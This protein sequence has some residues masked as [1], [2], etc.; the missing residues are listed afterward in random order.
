[1]TGICVGK[2]RHEC[3]DGGGHGKPL[4][5]FLNDDGTYSGFCFRCGEYVEDPFEGKAAP[6][7]PKKKT[8]EQIAEELREIS[9]EWGTQSVRDIRKEVLEHLGIKIGV[10]ETDGTTPVVMATPYYKDGE[11][12]AYKQ[13]TINTTP[14]KVWS[15]GDQSDVDLFGWEQAT[16]SGMKRLYITEGECFTPDAEVLTES[17]WITL[18]E[19]SM[20]DKVCQVNQD[21]TYSFVT[22]L[23][24]VKKQYEGNLVEY[25]SGSY[26][27]LT[28]P[29]HN[30]VRIHHKTG[31]LVKQKACDKKFY[32]AIPR[33]VN[34]SKG[35]LHVEELTARLQ[36]MFSAD[37]TFRK[38]GDLYGTFKEERKAIRCRELLKKWGGRYHESIDS[39]GYYSFFIHRGHGLPVSKLFNMSWLNSD[40]L[41]FIID[42]VVYW[43]GNR[44][45]NRDQIEF[46]SVLEHNADFIQAASH[47]CGYTSTKIYR[48]CTIGGKR[49]EWIKVSILFNKKYSTTHMG[50][51]IVEYKGSVMCATVPSGMLLV[52]QKGSISV[53][54]NCDAAALID[55]LKRNNRKEEYRDVFPAVVSLPHGAGAAAKDIAKVLPKIRQHFKE[56]VLV[57][58]MDAPGRKAVEEVCKIAPDFLS[59][60]LPCKDAN[61]CLQEGHIK[62]AFA[63]VMFKGARPKNSRIMSGSQLLEKALE[64][65]RKG[66]SYPWEGLTHLTRGMRFGELNFWAAGV[67]S[68]KSTILDA[69]GGHFIK[70]HSLPI[71]ACRFEEVPA[72]TYRNIVGKIAGIQ[73]VDPDIPIDMER[74]LEAEKLVRDKLLVYD[75]YQFARWDAM[76]ADI[77]YAIKDAGV[78]V[79]QIDPLTNLTA[80]MSAAEAND[81][82]AGWSVEAAA[83]AK[84]FDVHFDVAVH[85]KAPES[86]KD[87][88][89]GGEILANQIAGSRAMTRACHAIFGIGANKDP[90]LPEEQRNI[91]KIQLLEDRLTG[92]VG[93]IA[94]YYDSTTGVLKEIYP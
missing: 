58:D 47:L 25:K 59:A 34:N 74:F 33:V 52:R 7:P 43:D 60:E 70:E 62:T 18:A 10:S 31:E 63:A 2:L 20:E 12:V 46:S 1:M 80:G 85:L 16:N 44:V 90:T 11:I 3:Q 37:F 19:L 87:H 89:R 66:L 91:R 6:P 65:P 24:I 92:S 67:K 5:V 93:E 21:K 94:V 41:P 56:V 36:V 68:G 54:G 76:K 88:N 35:D 8:K 83:M 77:L 17:G 23:A 45:P 53:S 64:P 78:K 42:E 84:D 82:L 38:E 4:Q 28:T 50:Y 14:K 75:I 30:L 26:Y 49:Y 69:M 81:F 51:K 79:I 29:E 39:K 55:I 61:E 15:V 40:C 32:Q 57:F 27:S 9:E 13:I 48:E 86:G 22:P 71:L 72:H 73:V